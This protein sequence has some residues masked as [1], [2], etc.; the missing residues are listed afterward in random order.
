MYNSC[1]PT[2]AQGHRTI[3]GCGGVALA[4][5]LYY[6]SC[7]VHPQGSV[8]YS[9]PGFPTFH[10]NFANQ[11]Y[12]WLA[13]PH[14]QASAEN[15]KLLYH[16]AVAIYSTFG[17]IG[18]SS[19]TEEVPWAL[20]SKFGFNADLKER[21]HYSNDNWVNL[22]KAN[23]DNRRPIFY[24][25]VN[26]DSIGH[27]WVV[28]GYNSNNKFHCNFGW[29]GFN[30]GWFTLSDVTVEGNTFNT[31]QKAVVSIYTDY[32]TFVPIQNTTISSNTYTGHSIRVINCTIQNNANVV[33]D[34]DCMTEIHGPFTVPVGATLQV[35]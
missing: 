20:I 23:I 13:M 24:R 6:W 25:G 18:T 32:Y 14:S 12:N 34:A 35:K 3:V 22:L 31:E 30:D 21:K 33:F 2:D 19:T 7:N 11:T 5:I 1:C 26:N 10:I 17:V 29:L 8:T 16:S 15:A 4:Q 28:D 27:A 9:Q